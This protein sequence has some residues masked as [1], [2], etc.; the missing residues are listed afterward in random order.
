MYQDTLV[1]NYMEL[2]YVILIPCLT[3]GI[4]S[5]IPSHQDDS[6]AQH[7][8]AWGWWVRRRVL[9]DAPKLPAIP[10]HGQH[11]VQFSPDQH[12]H[13]AIERTR[14]VT[15]ISASLVTLPAKN[16]LM[17]T[18][19]QFTTTNEQQE[20]EFDEKENKCIKTKTTKT[21]ISVKYCMVQL[22]SLTLFL[23]CSCLNALFISFPCGHCWGRGIYQMTTAAASDLLPW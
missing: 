18:H 2:Q 4:K 7:S 13:L 22:D 15:H 10:L 9:A 8:P 11:V 19:Y 6:V 16:A 12:Q 17:Q 20:I 1:I 3:M 21:F 14:E 23:S 5:I